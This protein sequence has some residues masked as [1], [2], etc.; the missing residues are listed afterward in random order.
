VVLGTNEI[1]ILE[2]LCVVTEL[3]RKDHI[4]IYDG[5]VIKREGIVRMGPEWTL[6]KK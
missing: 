2:R 5:R 6:L 4:S 3:F 1:G